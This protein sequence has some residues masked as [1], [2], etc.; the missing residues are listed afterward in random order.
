LRAAVRAFRLTVRASRLTLRAS[1]LIV[2]ASRLT[3]RA[4]CAQSR[5]SRARIPADHARVW[6]I[7][8]AYDRNVEHPLH[9]DCSATTCRASTATHCVAQ[10]VPCKK[11]VSPMAVWLLLDPEDESCYINASGSD[12][13]HIKYVNEYPDYADNPVTVYEL[14]DSIADFRQVICW[15]YGMDDC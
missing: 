10:L 6:L 4:S 7:M 9:R 2:R 1:K 11:E 13:A 15:G 8:R 14:P 3:L 5:C 12:E